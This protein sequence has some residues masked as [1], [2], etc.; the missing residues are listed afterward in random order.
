M[1]HITFALRP[2]A[3]F[4][5]DLTAW[6]LRRKAENVI[7]RWEDGGSYRRVLIVQGHPVEVEVVQKGPPNM[8]LLQV[9]A[10]GSELF[11]EAETV[12]RS[13]L[14]RM[15]GIKA[16]LSE[17]YRFAKGQPKLDALV[18]RFRGVKPPRYPSLFE[19]LVNAIACQQVSLTVGILILGR[20]AATFGPS[21]SKQGV[22]AYGFPAPQSLYGVETDEL[23]TLGFSRQKARAITAT[24][25]AA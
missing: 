20:L 15:L 5:L 11:P 6:L 19:A 14:N 25:S 10:T 17:F 2:A 23:R 1:D 9:T 3:P 21:V 18:R 7:D 8:P 24:A 4:R 16:D 22:P 13:A 12:V